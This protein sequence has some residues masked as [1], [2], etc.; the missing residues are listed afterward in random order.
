MD[1][2]DNAGAIV[3]ITLVNPDVN[4]LNGYVI[5][6]GTGAPVSSPSGPAIYCDDATGRY[7]TW[8]EATAAWDLLAAEAGGQDETVV[9]DLTVGRDVAITRNETVGGTLAVTGA[10][11][12]A[13]YNGVYLYSGAADPSA[14]GGVA[15]TEPALYL[16]TGTDQLWM[17]TGSGATAWVQVDVSTITAV[18]GV[19]I[20][21]DSADPTSGGGVAGTRP[22]IYV[23]TGTD[24]IYLKNGAGNTNWS[25]LPTGIG[26]ATPP[27][28][29]SATAG[30]EG[31]STLSARRD[32]SHG[33]SKFTS[34]VEGLAG[35]I[36]FLG[37]DRSANL[38]GDT[39]FQPSATR[40]TLVFYTVRI[41]CGAGEVGRIQLLS[42]AANPPTTPLA[43][44]RNGGIVGLADVVDAVISTLVQPGHYVK[45]HAIQDT[46][47]PTFS[48]QTTA[49]YTL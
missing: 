12:G 8:N 26:G 25:L 2:I 5:A 22:A 46:G 14:G 10:V 45:L 24:Q 27:A 31:S 16:R 33:I 34:S 30:A 18:N 49:E 29:A 13:S 23:R 17:A 48:L 28:I 15:H 9:R 40:P 35:P 6:H 39:A 32:H 38:S 44:A 36:S 19:S 20:L 11:T 41:S 1:Y 7:Y 37:L 42:D 43:G 47:S 21:T 4:T 3:N